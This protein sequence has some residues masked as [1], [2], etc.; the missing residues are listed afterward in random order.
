MVRIS[1]TYDVLG[2]I[3]KPAIKLFN[4]LL[5]TTEDS[6]RNLIEMRHLDAY[7]SPNQEDRRKYTSRRTAILRE[8]ARFLKSYIRYQD[9]ITLK[10]NNK[11]AKLEAENASLR[12]ECDTLHQDPGHLVSSND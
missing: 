12:E 6:T 9:T 8:K 10:L 5:K 2:E 7:L 4:F 11:I 3:G 1:E